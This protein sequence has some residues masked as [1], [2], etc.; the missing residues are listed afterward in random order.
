MSFET[1]L[2]ETNIHNAFSTAKLWDDSYS[3]QDFNENI[4]TIWR[5]VYD[6]TTQLSK[7]LFIKTI[8]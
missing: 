4:K 2:E 7:F 6:L 3:Y 8:R 1:K 5:F